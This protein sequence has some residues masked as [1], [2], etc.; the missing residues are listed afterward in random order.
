M[1]ADEYALMDR[2]EDGM[3]WYR[4]AHARLAELL[5][6]RIAVASRATGE[7]LLDLGC[8]T[9]GVLRALR[10]ALPGLQL[11]GLDYDAGA[12]RRAS[13]KALAPVTCGDANR[14]PFRDRCFRAAVSVDVLCHRNVEEDAMLEELH[15][16]LVPGGLLVLNLPAFRWLHSAHDRRV[17]NARRY[18][19]PE[20]HR[21]LRRAGFAEIEAR[22]WNSLLLPLMVLQ[23]K[24]LAR[25]RDAPSDVAPFPPWLDRLL[26]GVDAAEQRLAR[27]G[28]R[29]PAGG[30]ILVTAIRR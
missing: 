9:G 12:A 27:A 24:L 1:E 25:R 4:A 28:L 14:L 10:T 5:Q 15:R 26:G 7:P 21:L 29:F 20:A 18:T 2:A 13:R 30:S 3:W 16:V 23:R 11:V 8:G 17:H 6:Q 22:Y 19:A